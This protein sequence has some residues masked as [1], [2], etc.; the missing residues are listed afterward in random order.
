MDLLGRNRE[1]SSLADDLDARRPALVTGEA[2]IGKTSVLRTAAARSGLRVFEGVCLSTLWWVSYQ[3]LRQALSLADS[4]VGADPPAVS[5]LVHRR[6]GENVLVLDDL[7]WADRDTRALLP[8]L[9]GRV[10]MLAGMRS[11][12]PGFAA[13]ADALGELGFEKYH[14]DGLGPAEIVEVA[15][16]TRPDLDPRQVGIVAEA[17]GGNPLFAE[18]LAKAGSDSPFVHAVVQSRVKDLPEDARRGLAKLALLG[19]PAPEPLAAALCGPGPLADLVRAELVEPRAGALDVRHGLIG[20]WALAEVCGSERRALHREVADLLDGAAERAQHLAA[21]GDRGD[22]YRA[23]LAASEQASTAGE[24]VAQLRLAAECADGDADTDELRIAA[25]AELVRARECEAAL[26]LAETVHGADGETLA[27]LRYWQAHAH[28]RLLANDEAAAAADEGA[29]VA[30][31]GS[32]VALKLREEDIR[33]RMFVDWNPFA[34]VQEAADLVR[35]AAAGGLRLPLA[36]MLGA[37]AGQILGRPGWEECFSAFSGKGRSEADWNLAFEADQALTTSLHMDGRTSEARELAVRAASEADAVGLARWAI[38]LRALGVAA[39]CFAGDYG[40]VLDTAPLLLAAH[41]TERDRDLLCTAYSL[42][43]VD[44]GHP[45]AAH[46]I[47]VAARREAVTVTGAVALPLVQA[48]IAYWTGRATRAVEIFEGHPYVGASG[49]PTVLMRPTHSW[50]CLDAGR[51]VPPP[52]PRLPFPLTDGVAAETAAIGRLAEGDRDAAA[53]AAGL[54]AEAAAAYEGCVF[55][56][57]LRSRWGRGTALLR[58]GEQ[59]EA[60]A[61]LRGVRT[62]A[63]AAGMTLLL[64]RIETSLREAESLSP[65]PPP[66]PGTS[67]LSKRER[68]TLALVA[69]GLTYAQIGRRLGI[70]PRT[71]EAHVTSVRRKLGAR[72]RAEAI[73]LA[74]DAS[75]E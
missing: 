42:A 40:E 59:D 69:A 67:V 37:L 3:P 45:E 34:V 60:V 31:P 44:R 5:D 73:L 58:A 65:P 52:F 7:Q 66:L 51:P 16:R 27:W 46:E 6:V 70:S 10:R 20:Q 9:A 63:D 30:P 13:E 57:E 41:P 54:F 56:S 35:D 38:Q 18:E 50:A 64:R 53:E 26:D 36:E 48:E 68:Q 75:R 22:A 74:E 33:R 1:L 49:M 71:V 17:A 8:L 14:L 19:R 23:A 4:D 12:G 61:E 28:A 25:V 62:A 55:R 21:A 39:A 72:T 15:R 47:V 32:E 11:G 2:G 43:L 29:R 24:R